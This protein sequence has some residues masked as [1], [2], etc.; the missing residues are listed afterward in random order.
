MS[1][2]K[3]YKNM[4]RTCTHLLRLDL[5]LRTSTST[6]TYIQAGSCFHSLDPATA[7]I[8]SLITDGTPALTIVTPVYC[9]ANIHEGIYEIFLYENSSAEVEAHAQA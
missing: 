3:K 6:S 4:R 1:D 7:S 2:L 9:P 5:Y 8:K